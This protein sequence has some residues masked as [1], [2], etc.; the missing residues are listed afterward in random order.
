MT[1]TIEYIKEWQQALQNEIV[2][3]KRFGS[4]KY[5]VANGRLLSNEGQFTYYFDSAAPIKIPNGSTV[6][7]EWGNTKQ[8][9]RILS[10]EGRGVIVA[11][12]KF[13]GDLIHNAI[14][15]HDPWELLE[16][17]IQRFD[18]IKK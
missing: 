14:L 8:D 3:L 6:K 5:Q 1:T 12:E 4:N 15:Y 10:A 18:E 2:H 16:Q 9:G 13:I 17:L 7:L 11:L